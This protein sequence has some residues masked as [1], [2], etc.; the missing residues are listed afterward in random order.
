MTITITKKV[1][2]KKLK[3]TK[4]LDAKKTPWESKM[5]RRCA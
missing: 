4:K 5:G 2:K 3:Q 1:G